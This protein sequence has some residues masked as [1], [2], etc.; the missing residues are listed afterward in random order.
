MRGTLTVSP[1]LLPIDFFENLG[2]SRSL[3]YRRKKPKKILGK[4]SKNE[5]EPTKFHCRISNHS[6][7]PRHSTNSSK[8]YSGQPRSPAP[9]RKNLEKIQNVGIDDVLTCTEFSRLGSNRF[10]IIRLSTFWEFP[11]FSKL[12]KWI[13][14]KNRK[15]KIAIPASL[16]HKLVQSAL[17]VQIWV[18][19]IPICSLYGAPPI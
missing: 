8:K 9:G 3:S 6:R 16:V 5:L 17:S 11:S 13:F 1:R 10:W 2:R 19:L 14:P 7:F 12:I 18:W 15:K 4:G